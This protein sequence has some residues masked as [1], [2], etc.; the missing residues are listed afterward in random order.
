MLITR[1]SAETIICL[2]QLF[3]FATNACLSPASIPRNKKTKR[4]GILAR[5]T[6]ETTKKPALTP[7]FSVT[8]AT[9]WKIPRKFPNKIRHPKTGDFFFSKI[10]RDAGIQTPC[11]ER[12]AFLQPLLVWKNAQV[13]NSAPKGDRFQ[14]LVV[15]VAPTPVE[16]YIKVCASQLGF[17]SQR[18]GWT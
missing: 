13:L 11:V 9:V 12:W 18:S 8:N 17:F 5:E 4:T 10:D 15:E 2:L 1:Y 16:S 3:S 14:K 7:L 6:S